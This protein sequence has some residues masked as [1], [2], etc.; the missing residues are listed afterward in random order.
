MPA[1]EI[2]AE[3]I[4]DNKYDPR[5]L[6]F[7]CVFFASLCVIIGNTFYLVNLFKGWKANKKSNQSAP[8]CDIFNEN[9]IGF[10]ALAKI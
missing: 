8:G 6:G 1:T 2:L 10:L 5:V 3:C 4:I 9:I 7:G